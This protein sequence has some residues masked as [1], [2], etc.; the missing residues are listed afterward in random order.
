MSNPFFC[1]H[2]W[3][4]WSNPRNIDIVEW[5]FYQIHKRQATIQ[6]RICEKC[7]KYQVKT[8]KTNI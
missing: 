6:D 1:W 4:K 2:R 7:G 5:I 3:G 8:I